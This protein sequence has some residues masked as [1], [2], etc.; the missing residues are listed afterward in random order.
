LDAA[1]GC[2]IADC[3]PVECDTGAQGRNDLVSAT[4]SRGVELRA[5]RADQ[6]PQRALEK[7]GDNM[8]FDILQWWEDY[9][10]HVLAHM[11][12]NVDIRKYAPIVAAVLAA[13][14]AIKKK[15]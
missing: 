1:P 2:L 11:P 9:Y 6:M 4:G 7:E 10:K 13:A 5:Q 8:D 12:N 14:E 3:H 15:P